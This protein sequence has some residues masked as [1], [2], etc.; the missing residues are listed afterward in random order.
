MLSAAVAATLVEEGGAWFGNYFLRRTPMTEE[1][2][3]AKF[4]T[5]DTGAE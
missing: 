1:E 4:V 2:W 5:S 3:I